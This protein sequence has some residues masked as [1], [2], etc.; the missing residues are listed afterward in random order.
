MLLKLLGEE[1]PAH[2]ITVFAFDAAE[3]HAVEFFQARFGTDLLHALLDRGL[4]LLLHLFVAHRHAVLHGLCHD[5]FL[6]D[7]GLQHLGTDARGTGIDPVVHHEE[8][9]LRLEFGFQD[10][11]VLHDGHDPVEALGTTCFDCVWGCSW[12][13]E[14]TVTTARTQTAHST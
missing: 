6:V 12:A 3:G 2:L 9:D 7:H 14:A 13:K 4:E 1:I 10:G 8:L 5:Q 11:I